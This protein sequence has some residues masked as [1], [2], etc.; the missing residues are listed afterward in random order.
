MKRLWGIV[1]VL[2]SACGQAP[3]F[4]Q[5]NSGAPEV[6]AL[7]ITPSTARPEPQK[8]FELRI[9]G[10]WPV[11]ATAL[12]PQYPHYITELQVLDYRR[13]I[14]DVNDDRLL[15]VRLSVQA[16]MSGVYRIP[17]IPVA[18]E[19][20]GGQSAVLRTL[21]LFMEI[22]LEAARDVTDIRDIKPLRSVPGSLSPL[23][24]VGLAAMFVLLIGLASVGMYRWRKRTRAAPTA[25]EQL[26]AV[27]RPYLSDG[28]A[29]VLDRPH[30]FALSEATRRYV[31][32]RDGLR[33]LEM[34]GSEFVM[35]VHSLPEPGRIE[36]LR[37]LANI[38]RELEEVKFR[39]QSSAAIPSAR[40]A[41]RI[42]D[43]AHACEQQLVE[44]LARER[45]TR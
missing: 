6:P 31:E 18:L 25:I 26:E 33:A 42:W 44:Q 43:A 22:T 3:V 20:P 37:E 23:L 16:A 41:A 21:P 17:P 38:C 24:W 12:E 32:Q 27:L 2:V 4:Q 39:P 40:L 8:P 7:D 14:T 45:A 5:L 28:G 36:R 15:D 29:Q 19:Y 11:T 35:A 10:H 9:Q 30:A 34:T 13:S 1:I